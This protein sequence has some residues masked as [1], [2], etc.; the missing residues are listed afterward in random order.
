MTELPVAGYSPEDPPVP[1]V[2]I[3][4]VV[5]DIA[6]EIKPE[7]PLGEV[8]VRIGNV[9]AVESTTPFRVQLDI[10]GTAWLSRTADASMK[11]GDR[12][13]AVQQGE[14]VIAAGRLNS[15]DSFTPI[16]S[17]MPYAGSAAPTGW[18][19]TDGSAV[20]RT[21]YAALFAV[22]GTTYGSGNGTTTFNLPNLQN[23]VPVGSGSTY[24]RGSTGG[25]ASITLTSG[26]LPSHSHS[27][28]SSTDS[29]GS[30]SHSGSTGSASHS[31]SVG[32]QN[33]RSDILAGG[34]TTTASTGGGSTG[35]DSHSH[36]ITVDSGGGHTHSMSGS[37]GST[38]SGSSVDNMQPYLAMPYIIRAL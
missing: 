28:S 5:A 26:Q 27:F 30:H 3:A 18:L 33:S 19:L 7:N 23:R 29:G 35:S 14:V 11:I 16:G 20:S 37:T 34:G 10:T 32:N 38:G 25:S 15:I 24:S 13:W 22:C 8:S 12:V 9:T 17:M 31:H 2:D 1:P 36:S 6:A 4:S 21:T